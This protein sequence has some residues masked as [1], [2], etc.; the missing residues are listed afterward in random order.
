MTPVAIEAP[1][2]PCFAAYDP[3]AGPAMLVL[4]PFG[5]E[6]QATHRVWRSLAA[7]LA[8]EGTAVLRLDLPGTGDSAGELTVHACRAAID[9]A[10]TW[11]AARHGAVSLLGCRFGALFALDSVGRG[12]PVRSL[13]LL[14][15]PANGQALARQLRARSRTEPGGGSDRRAYGH[16][17][18]DDLLADLTRLPAAI[19]T[20]PDTLLI[21]DDPAWAAALAAAGAQVETVPFEE[22]DAFLM[23]NSFQVRPPNAALARI[24]AFARARHHPRALPE[25]RPCVLQLPGL[26]E[27]PIRFGPGLFGVLCRPDRPRGSAVLIPSTGNLPRPGPGRAS[28]LLAR[29]LAG[30]GITSL[31]YDCAAAGDSEGEPASDP[32]VETC[33]PGHIA[34][35]SLALDALGCDRVVVVGHCSGAYI[36]W[37][38]AQ[39]DRRIAGLIALNLQA[40][41]RMEPAT[42]ASVIRPDGETKTAKANAGRQPSP[43]RLVQRA[44]PQPIWN[45]L[46]SM[47]PEERAI[48]RSLRSLTARGCPVHFIYGDEEDEAYRFRRA[49]GVPVRLPAGAE[50]I[51]LA[52]ADHMLAAAHH[53]ARLREHAARFV[54]NLE[55]VAA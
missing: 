36:G 27:E 4:A 49:F 51:V 13:V 7:A 18:P 25:V 16:P 39:H 20:A 44:C 45:W 17:V 2:G 24:L 28:V 38:A 35:V 33:L 15:P 55:G 47:Q 41:H 53:Q 37:H 11:L 31:R 52:G 22:R 32:A 48:R 26:N 40:L 50:A 34:H 23:R 29:H 30:L 54:L 6:G 14:D 43:T 46:R 5:Y 19:T 10:V 1:A 42:V 21:Q 8:A 3:A 9:A 12:V